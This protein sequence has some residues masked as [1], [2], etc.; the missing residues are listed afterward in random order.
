MLQ[1]WYYL[2]YSV[3]K[4]CEVNYYVLFLVSLVSCYKGEV[5]HCNKARLVQKGGC[6]HWHFYPFEREQD[7]MQKYQEIIKHLLPV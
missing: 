5:L 6:L 4:C 3:F 1:G 7:L 2:I